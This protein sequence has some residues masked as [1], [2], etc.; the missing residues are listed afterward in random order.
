MTLLAK[1]IEKGTTVSDVEIHEGLV[2]PLV[3]QYN[4]SN[5]QKD[6]LLLLARRYSS[7]WFGTMVSQPDA[8][9]YIAEE[10]DDL[11]ELIRSEG[12]PFHEACIDLMNAV[13]TCLRDIAQNAEVEA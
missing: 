3:K 7:L 10:I 9:E 11:T 5:S 13:A 12:E 2:S 1:N 4:L 8:D 6:D